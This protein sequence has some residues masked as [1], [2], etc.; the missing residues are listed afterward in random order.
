MKS[1]VSL[2]ASSGAAYLIAKS[3]DSRKSLAFEDVG[4]KAIHKLVVYKLPV[5]VAANPRG[6]SDH[7]HGT[8][9]W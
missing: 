5:I 9:Q 6:N 7:L 4:T 8:K 2:V 1:V 3:I